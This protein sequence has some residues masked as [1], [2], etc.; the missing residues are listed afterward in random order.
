[1]G[2]FAT[3]EEVAADV[4]LTK[5]SWDRYADFLRERNE[6]ANK[7]WLS[8]RDQVGANGGVWMRT[9]EGSECSPNRTLPVHCDGGVAF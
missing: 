3:L 8:M 7:D 2:D 5:S 1:M 4:A 9:L 6:M